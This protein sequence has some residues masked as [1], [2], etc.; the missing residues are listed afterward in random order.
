MLPAIS[1]ITNQLVA[2]QAGAADAPAVSFC[3]T[4]HWAATNWFVMSEIAGNKEVKLYPESIVGWSKS[5]LP[6]EN[7]PSRVTALI[8]DVKRALDK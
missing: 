3:N 7:E 5:P 8:Q 6:M 4:G 1:D 2:A